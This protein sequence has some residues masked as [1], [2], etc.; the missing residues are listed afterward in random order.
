MAGLSDFSGRQGQ[1]ISKLDAEV[2]FFY[3]IFESEL[4]Q[5]ISFTA[6]C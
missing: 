5:Y 6:H 4:V 1:Q 3:G 2:S